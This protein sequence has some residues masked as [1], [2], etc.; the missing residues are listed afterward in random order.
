MCIKNYMC[1][2]HLVMEMKKSIQWQITRADVKY[3]ITSGM[4]RET[5]ENH[6]E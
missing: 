1:Q 6:V 5:S 3:Y 4:M 2:S